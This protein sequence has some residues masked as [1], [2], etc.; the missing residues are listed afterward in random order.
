MAA[1]TARPVMM[2]AAQ[3]VFGS[4]QVVYGV[5]RSVAV[6]D[7]SSSEANIIYIGDEE[8]L[9]CAVVDELR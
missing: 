3:A 8:R 6:S 5:Q 4:D 2:V 1:A 9:G 7:V